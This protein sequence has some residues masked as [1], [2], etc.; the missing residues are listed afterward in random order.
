MK[1][2]D[3]VKNKNLKLSLSALLVKPLTKCYQVCAVRAMF[4]K[5]ENNLSKRRQLELILN[6]DKRIVAYVCSITLLERA[7]R[8]KQKDN[9][10]ADFTNSSS[11]EE[12]TGKL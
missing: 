2:K 5:K 9:M 6:R 12:E 11:E 3:R 1:Q 4:N 7:K 8:K 10:K